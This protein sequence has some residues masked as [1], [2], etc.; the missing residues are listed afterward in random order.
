[1]LKKLLKYDLRAIL[2]YWWIVAL[3]SLGTSLIGGI[4][5]R[6]LFPLLQKPELEGAEVFIAIFSFLGLI[7]SILGISAF[8]IATEIFIYIRLYRHLFSDEGY[9]TFTLPVK[10]SE[11]LNS[12]LLSGLIINFASVLIVILDIFIFL[13]AGIDHS[14]IANV[15]SFIGMMLSSAFELWGALSIAYILE[16]VLL[17]LCLSL[18]SYLFIAICMTFA[19]MIAKKYKIFAAIGIYYVVSAVITFIGQLAIMFGSIGLAALLSSLDPSYIPS[20]IAL[21]LLSLC[22]ILSALTYCLYTLELYM[23]D[24]KLNLS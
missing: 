14:E 23:L 21:L 12:K 19:A 15:L 24:K 9:L 20:V 6:A 3:S 7:M 4:S 13:L 10:R 8:I 1:M 18:V 5:L 22:V 11:I 17:L 2:K 16:A